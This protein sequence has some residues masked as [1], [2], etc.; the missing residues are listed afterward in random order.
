[1]AKKIIV[2]N[3]L[4]REEGQVKKE[5]VKSNNQQE[6]EFKHSEGFQLEVNAWSRT[7]T[8]TEEKKKQK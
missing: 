8:S 5:I 7:E 4:H 6:T 3:N 2:G 1:M